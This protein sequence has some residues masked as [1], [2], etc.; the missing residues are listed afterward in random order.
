MVV[1]I[2]RLIQTEGNEVSRLKLSLLIAILICLFVNTDAIAEIMVD[3][4]H[5]NEPSLEQNNYRKGEIGPLGG[6]IIYVDASGKHGIEAKTEDNPGSMTWNVAVVVF[7]ENAQDWRLPTIA[8]LRMLYEQR[9]MIGG[10]GNE[11]YWS[12]TEQDI[13]SAWIQG[14]RLG[15]QDRY[16]KQSK[17]KV[18][19]VRSF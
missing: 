3:Q 13:N 8:E 18:R 7:Q 1:Y 16:N 11:D 4:P 12:S 17:L 5:K 15:D 10:F 9:K 19:A 6:K 14:F 2:D